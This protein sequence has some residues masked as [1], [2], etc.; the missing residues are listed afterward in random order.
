[1]FSGPCFF[2]PDRWIYRVCNQ[3][4]RIRLLPSL[5]SSCVFFSAT[6]SGREDSLRGANSLSPPG[7][8][9]RDGDVK[10]YIFDIYKPTELAHSFFNLFL[11]LFLFLRPFQL[12]FIR[13]ILP[14]TLRLLTLF[15]WSYLCFIVPFNYVSLYESLLQP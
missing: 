2:A 8:P 15:F 9:S 6:P 14:T 4:H 10:V 1:M 7:S 3:A 11:C 13:L 5:S 12:Y